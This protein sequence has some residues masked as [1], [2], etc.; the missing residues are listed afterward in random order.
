MELIASL[1]G[2]EGVCL[3]RGSI[4]RSGGAWWSVEGAVEGVGVGLAS[5]V[6]AGM[7]P[8]RDM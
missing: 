8:V 2:C 4:G 7:G 1:R 5:S 3:A 6:V